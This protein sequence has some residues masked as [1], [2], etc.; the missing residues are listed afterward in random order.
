V[1]EE[2]ALR[3]KRSVDLC[4]CWQTTANRGQKKTGAG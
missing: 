1:P 3:G 2:Q 4:A